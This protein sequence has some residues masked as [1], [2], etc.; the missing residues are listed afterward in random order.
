MLLTNQ[1]GLTYHMRH[2]L[3][4]LLL[5]RRVRA[6]KA[7]SSSTHC[8]RVLP[9]SANCSS[10]DT[11]RYIGSMRLTA[12]WPFPWTQCATGYV[13]VASLPQDRWPCL[14]SIFCGPPAT[15]SAA[16]WLIVW[17]YCASNSA[18]ERQRSAHGD[19]FPK[20]IHR[21]RRNRSIFTNV[22]PSARMSGRRRVHT[23][24][25]AQLREANQLPAWS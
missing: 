22:P 2:S 1:N 4:L 15:G 21:S 14:S 19:Q 20:V 24:S 7:S 8:S 17:R 10:N 9:R 12:K 11:H 6:G 25:P 13:P 23:L 18:S 3:C 5:P 16:T